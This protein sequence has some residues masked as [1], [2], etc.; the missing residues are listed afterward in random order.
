VVSSPNPS[1]FGQVVV[2]TFTVVGPG[3]PT[4]GSV[5][6]F[7]ASTRLGTVLLAGGQATFASSDLTAGDHAISARFAEAGSTTTIR[8]AQI[9]HTV[10]GGASAGITSRSGLAS[11]GGWTASIGLA[12]GLLGLVTRF[13][14]RRTA[15][16]ST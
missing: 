13:A 3:P 11:T 6:F 2:F 7:D 4:T 14:L 10:T 12:L 16:P 5:T 15:I 8:S 9:R 1:A